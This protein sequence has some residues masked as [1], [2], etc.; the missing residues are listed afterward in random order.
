MFNSFISTVI[1]VFWFILYAILF[2]F[3]NVSC[4]IRSFFPPFLSFSLNE[5]FY[6]ETFLIHLITFFAMFFWVIFLVAD[7]SDTHCAWGPVIHAGNIKMDEIRGSLLSGLHRN[8]GNNLYRTCSMPGIVLNASCVLAHVTFRTA[9]WGQCYY[10]HPCF[11][12]GEMEMQ[13]GWVTCWV[14]KQVSNRTRIQ[15]QAVDLSLG[16]HPYS[17]Y[18]FLFSDNLTN[19]I[20]SLILVAFFLITVINNHLSSNNH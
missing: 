16:S 5:Y 19:I 13:R 10:S 6:S 14:T 17:A 4:H 20:I 9:P 3:Q 2:H 18:T 11:L 12:G 8:D 15:T 1:D 7:R